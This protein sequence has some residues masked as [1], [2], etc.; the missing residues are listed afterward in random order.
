MLM[1]GRVACKLPV[2]DIITARRKSD[3]HPTDDTRTFPWAS[4]WRGGLIY[5]NNFFH[6]LSGSTAP[7][8]LP[9]VKAAS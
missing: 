6:F 5:P 4:P 2:T 1:S 9:S 7:V 3:T 8:M